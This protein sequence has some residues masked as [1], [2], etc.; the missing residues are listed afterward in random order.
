MPRTNKHQTPASLPSVMPF[1]RAAEG[2]GIKYTT[3]RDAHHRGDLAVIKI[4]R[5]WYVELAA[6]T[7]FVEQHTEHKTA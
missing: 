5:A 1:K 6:L 7:R 4:G 3:L 2:C